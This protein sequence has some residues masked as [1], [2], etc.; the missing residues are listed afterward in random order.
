MAQKEEVKVAGIDDAL[1]DEQPGLR[2]AA[3][4]LHVLLL[5]EEASVVGLLEHA[6]GHG[7]AVFA[8]KTS[9]G[10]ANRCELAGQH[11][12]KKRVRRKM[13]TIFKD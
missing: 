11:L 5:L 6:K 2:V 10:A 4:I 13:L 12:R 1:V 8:G 9:A 3:A 7:R